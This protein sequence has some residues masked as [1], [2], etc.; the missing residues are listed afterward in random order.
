MEQSQKQIAIGDPELAAGANIY[1]WLLDEV[2]A[3]LFEQVLSPE[4]RLELDQ[5]IGELLGLCIVHRVRH[6]RE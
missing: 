3:H 1:D 4:F 2:D 5:Q 6:L